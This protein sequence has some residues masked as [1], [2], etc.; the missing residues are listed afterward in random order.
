MLFLSL[1]F[2]KEHKE[3][4]LIQPVTTCSH[5][6]TGWYGSWVSRNKR[7]METSKNWLSKI[8]LW[9]KFYYPFTLLAKCL[10]SFW[11]KSSCWT[12]S[13]CGPAKW[14][15]LRILYMG[16]AFWKDPSSLNQNTH[17]Y[18]SLP[19][20]FWIPPQECVWDRN[21]TQLFIFSE[22]EKSFPQKTRHH[23]FRVDLYLSTQKFPIVLCLL[24]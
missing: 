5:R 18:L 9:P 19:K 16:L 6:S 11:N 7:K 22:K 3:I 1:R 23:R 8:L 10:Y 12:T 17:C 20:H 4:E 15:P 13:R 21:V 2:N 14:I 24:L